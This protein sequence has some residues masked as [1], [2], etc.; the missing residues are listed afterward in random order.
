MFVL[1]SICALNSV[2][3]TFPSINTSE[4]VYSTSS[5][6]TIGVGLMGEH[7]LD[8]VT[9]I[10]VVAAANVAWE[11]SIPSYTANMTYETANTQARSSSA[12]HLLTVDIR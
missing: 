5:G 9:R 12:H 8:L 1:G 11:M 10:Q 4:L 3:S 2:L 7:A 6:G